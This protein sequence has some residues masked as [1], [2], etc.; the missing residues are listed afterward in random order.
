MGHG[1]VIV[2]ELSWSLLCQCMLLSAPYQ[3]GLPLISHHV[4]DVWLPY[5]P[6]QAA[7]AVAAADLQVSGDYAG[8]QPLTGML[9]GSTVVPRKATMRE[10]VFTGLNSLMAPRSVSPHRHSSTG[11]AITPAVEHKIETLVAAPA[12]VEDAL[13]SLIVDNQDK[14]HA[15]QYRALVTY[16]KRIYHPFLMCEPQVNQNGAMLTA[17]WMFHGP[18]TAQTAARKQTMG[19]FLVLPSLRDLHK[20]LQVSILSAVSSASRQRSV[21]AYDVYC[22]CAGAC[23]CMSVWQAMPAMPLQS[24][25]WTSVLDGCIMILHPAP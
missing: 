10:G 3:P 16:V 1:L 19:A 9:G 14:Y 13:A 5:G 21:S 20:G 12:A 6:G 2:L 17:T 23:V 4:I 22:Q 7:G 18:R 8:Q 24:S 15:L 25:P 11:G